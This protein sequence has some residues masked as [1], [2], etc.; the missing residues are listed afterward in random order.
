MQWHR[1]VFLSLGLA[2]LVVPPLVAQAPQFRADVTQTGDATFEGTMYFGSGRMRIEGMSDGQQMT[3]II[4]GAANTMIVLMPED[5]A[6]MSMDLGAA[7]FTAPGASSMDPANPC[8]SGEVTDCRSL[9][10]ETVNGYAAR[11]WEY[12]RD[13]ERETAWIATELRFPVRIVEADG[14]TTDFANVQVGA[15]PASLFQP[16]GDYTAM[17]IPGFGGFGGGR[18]G[19]PGRGG[20]GQVPPGAAGRGAVPPGAGRGAPAGTPAGLDPTAAAQMTAQLQAMG[21]SPDQI[22]AALAQMGLSAVATNSAPWEAGDGWVV[23]LVVTASGS[24]NFTIAM[25]RGTGV[26]RYSARYTASVPF[27][28]G[29]PAVGAAMGPAWQLVPGAGSPRGLA[30]PLVFSAESEFRYEGQ[31]VAACPIDDASVSQTVARGRASLRTTDHSSMAIMTTQARW[32]ISGDLSS[33]QLM[34]AVGAEATEEWETTTTTQGACSGS[35]STTTDRETRTP[36]F[37]ISLTLPGLPLA[38]SPGPMRGTVTA[39]M[40][41]TIGGFA[42]DLDANVEWTVRPIR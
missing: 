4:D 34:V 41:F 35:P 1:S 5:R 42:G 28:Y 14:T 27:P 21:L 40:R 11:G 9:G 30:E 33:H 23:D 25:P 22:A 36:M 38:G 15:Q 17:T 31:T 10:T 8:G 12:T 3:A 6:Y 37:A 13:G 26:N 20:R 24:E 2:L 7:P 29:T 19:P 16:P 39:P 32:E 18:G